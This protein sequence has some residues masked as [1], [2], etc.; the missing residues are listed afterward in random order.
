MV[1]ERFM[2]EAGGSDAN[3]VV[4]TTASGRKDLEEPEVRQKFIDGFKKMGQKM[5]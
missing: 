3:L 5:W 4:I 1:F 2:E